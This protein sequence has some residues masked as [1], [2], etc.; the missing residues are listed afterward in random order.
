[1]PETQ[2]RCGAAMRRCLRATTCV[3]CHVNGVIRE[4]MTTY[5]RVKTLSE[6]VM[7]RGRSTRCEY[8]SCD[9]QFLRLT[10]RQR[11]L[12]ESRCVF[13]AG[14]HGINSA[15]CDS[16]T[17]VNWQTRET[18]AAYTTRRTVVKLEITHVLDDEINRTCQ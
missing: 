17:V 7:A 3:A 15:F 18:L 9:V 1:M 11:S 5:R 16:F 12:P 14:A 10:R 8:V 4:R 13:R 2:N 6:A